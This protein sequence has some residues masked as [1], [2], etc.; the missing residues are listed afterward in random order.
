MSKFCAI[1]PVEVVRWKGNGVYE[2][3]VEAWMPIPPTPTEPR[4]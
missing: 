3:A 4:A 1:G 2:S